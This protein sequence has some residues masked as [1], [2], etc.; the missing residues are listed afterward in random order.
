MEKQKIENSQSNL[1]RKKNKCEG[2]RIINYQAIV[3][4][5]HGISGRIDRQIEGAEEAVQHFTLT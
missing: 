3:I 5:I 2:L 1:E 4:Q